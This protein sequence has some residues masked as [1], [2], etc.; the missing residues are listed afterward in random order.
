[1]ASLPAGK[2]SESDEW[3]PSVMAPGQEMKDYLPKTDPVGPFK[4]PQTENW[5]EDTGGVS[6]DVTT[7]PAETSAVPHVGLQ[8]SDTRDSNATPGVCGLI[9]MGNTCYMNA[10]L[11]CVYNIPGF[12]QY[13]FGVHDM[14]GKEENSPEWMRQQLEI[15]FSLLIRKYWCGQYQALHPKLFK[16]V[17]G[18]VHPQL[19]G[20]RQQDCQEFLA[21]LLGSLQDNHVAPKTTHK[22]QSSRQQGADVSKPDDDALSQQQ[23]DVLPQQQS[24]VTVASS[25]DDTS[26]TAVVQNVSSDASLSPHHGDDDTAMEVSSPEEAK[27]NPLDIVKEFQ[28]VLHNEVLCSVCGYM[29]TKE[30]PFLFLSLPL[31]HAYERQIKITWIPLSSRDNQ[32]IPTR[33]IV[34]VLHNVTVAMVKEE[35][36]KMLQLNN[37]LSTGSV[38]LAEVLTHYI[39]RVLVSIS[40]L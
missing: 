38:I 12:C 32:C 26:E 3:L 16:Q 13:F 21:L 19:N 20:F 14:E 30:E 35:L 25:H 22:G 4:M 24:D 37:I 28:G 27:T 1:M 11:Q 6:N 40:S 23:D 15:Q 34:T 8:P 31:P 5:D 9:N 18:A 29:S 33:V 39:H 17:L 10:G 7:A 36:L 2:G